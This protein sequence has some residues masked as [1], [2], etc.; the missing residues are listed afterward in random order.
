[1]TLKKNQLTIGLIFCCVTLM[2]TCKKDDVPPNPY[3]V[4][5][6]VIENDNPDVDDLPV[7]SFAWLHGKIFKPTCANSGCH[8]GTFEPEFRTIASAYNSLVNQPVIAN[9]PENSFVYR[10]NP[11]DTALSFL[12]ERLTVFV[13][14]TSG[15]M[16]LDYDPNSDWPTNK[17]FYIQ[18][19]SNWIESGAPDM[20]GNP[21]P[22]SQSNLPPLV[23]GLAAFPE[24]NTTTPF[25]RE[26]G[27]QT[28]AILVDSA[29]IDIW[30]FPYD[31]NALLT[32]FES[33]SIKVST[34]PI[35]FTGAVEVPCE[36]SG[37]VLALDFGNS[38]T[39]FHYKATLDLSGLPIGT[40]YYVRCYL[41]DG[42]QTEI[43][44]IP[45]SSSTYFYYLL[46]SLK[47]VS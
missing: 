46:F 27:E 7:G 38:P 5:T 17:D 1:M 39:N 43:T 26:T 47:V 18:Q 10:V 23:Y 12:H 31:D 36:I 34:N 19:I 24:D 42:V 4:S 15:M 20:M 41:N 37:P 11:G 3:A 14:N 32:D 13:E 29:P 40:I 25:P 28:S 21:A 45:N 8:D 22:S 35:D 16:P 6:V 33:V 44:E 2:W 9:N 30:L